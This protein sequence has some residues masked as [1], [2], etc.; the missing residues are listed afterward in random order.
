MMIFA[1]IMSMKTFQ[2]SV[3]IL[4]LL[5]AFT[6]GIAQNLGAV[7]RGQRGYVPPPRALEAGEP[8][9][10]D[11][12]VMAQENATRYAQELNIDAFTKEVLKS[13]LK[14]FYR[15]K[16]DISYNPELKFDDKQPLIMTAN[17]KFEKRLTEILNADQIEAL[18][19]FE[20]LGMKPKDDKKKK[21]KKKKDKS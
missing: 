1:K 17:S 2:K 10:P 9:K 7:Q 19:S 11:V 15:E 18:I 4:F 20:Q 13:Y 3:C 16:I 14:D 21:K 12:N 5:G 6:T 8:E